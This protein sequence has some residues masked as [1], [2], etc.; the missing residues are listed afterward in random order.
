MP[1]VVVVA[2]N[3]RDFNG[4]KQGLHQFGYSAQRVT[5]ELI[6]VFGYAVPM[7]ML[8]AGA[9]VIMAIIMLTARALPV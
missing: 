8:A 9:A 6:Q 1:P 4:L 3:N 7:S 2:F 5:E